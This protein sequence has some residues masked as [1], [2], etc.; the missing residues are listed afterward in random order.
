M[1]SLN[2]SNINLQKFL[3]LKYIADWLFH[4]TL[5][6]RSN[7]PQNTP[8]IIKLFDNHLNF[9]SK[10]EIYENNK[11]FLI[12]VN[13]LLIKELMWKI[14]RLENFARFLEELNFSFFDKSYMNFPGYYYLVII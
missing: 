13:V 11:K 8:F 12:Q 4:Q 10:N 1:L 7:D 3:E 5:Y 2:Y 9:F 6:I 14:V